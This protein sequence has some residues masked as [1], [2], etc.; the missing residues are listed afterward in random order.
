MLEKF[1][2]WAASPFFPTLQFSSVEQFLEQVDSQA[3]EQDSADAARET[4]SQEAGVSQNSQ[5]STKDLNL[6]LKISPAETLRE[7]NSKLIPT[8]Y[9]ELYLELHRGCYTTHA[10]QKWFNRRCE[11]WLYQA[12]LWAAIASLTADLPYPRADLEQAWKQV[13]FNQFHDILPGTAIAEVFTEANQGWQAALQSAQAIA[14]AA[15]RA[16]AAQVTTPA[17]PQPDAV[18]VLV[19]NS[20]A[21]QRS[22][23]VEISLPIA[24]AHW[25]VLDSQG[26]C[27]PSQP[28]SPTAA[29]P[30]LFFLAEISSVGYQLF[31]LTPQLPNS[32]TPQLPPPFILQNLYLQA[33]LD[34]QTGDLIQLYDRTQNR[35][36]L[37]APANQLQAFQ[38]QGQYWDAWNIAPD[39]L[40]H[41]LPPA[42]LTAIEWIEAG[43]VRQRLRVTRQLGQSTFVQDY[44]LDCHSPRLVIETTADWQE[45]QVVLKVAFPLAVE[46]EV[47]TYEIPFGAI[48]R[49]TRPQAPA[50]QVSANQAPADQAKWEVPALRWADLSDS[51]GGLSILTDCK[52]GFDAAPSQLRLTLLKSPLWPDPASDRGQHRF[53]YALYPHA[54]G[55]QQT[56]QQA[57]ALNIP[58]QCLVNPAL[59]LGKLPPAQGF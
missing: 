11:D 39:Y 27:C 2:R 47:A 10:E 44:V 34:P 33:T 59:N 7:Q 53:T 51:Q 40:D 16:I 20:L 36:L 6:P 4:N 29:A 38:D 55:P 1:R 50:D 12:E 22:E 19:F 18:P 17:P 21:W 56:P 41:P 3:Q 32:P 5:E 48:A 35:E 37:S 9:D 26:Q 58:L 14:K 30:N 46:A 23:V 24:A 43:P 52:H 42:Q 57:K 28:A 49:L 25:Q 45:T 8:W 15:L 13:L 54:A 31:W